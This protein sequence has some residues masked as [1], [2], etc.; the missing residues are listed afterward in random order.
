MRR[1]WTKVGVYERGNERTHARC[2][3]FARSE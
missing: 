2:L 3:T 1:I